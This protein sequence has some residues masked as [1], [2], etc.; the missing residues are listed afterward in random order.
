MN[1]KELVQVLKMDHDMKEITHYFLKQVEKEKAKEKERGRKK[2]LCW[3]YGADHWKR[4]CPKKNKRGGD[5][6]S[7]EKPSISTNAVDNDDNC[8]FMVEELSDD[9]IGIEEEITNRSN[10]ERLEIA[11]NKAVNVSEPSVRL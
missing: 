10:F 3:I 8:T 7:T 2:D 11:T 4:D 1:G 5:N 6:D 9:E